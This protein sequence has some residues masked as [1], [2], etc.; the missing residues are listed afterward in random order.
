MELIGR[1]EPAEKLRQRLRS[2]NAELVAVLGRRRVGK[3]FL[4][5]QVLKKEIV[6]HYTG[7]HNGT[8]KENLERFSAT[9]SNAMDLSIR[10][11]TPKNWFEAFDYLRTFIITH[12]TKK[13]K[14]IFLDEFPWIATNKSKFLVA[15]TDFW[16][17]FAADRQDIMVVICGSSA[18]W[19]I[20]KVL[21]N[22]GGL[23]NRVTD[24]IFL[25]PFDLKETKSFLRNK[26]IILTDV[27]IVK[28]YMAI[29]GIP[30]YLEQ[31]QK[32]ESIV[33]GID[34]VCFEKGALL[35][36]EYNELLTSL[37]D[38]AEKHQLV[39]DLLSE[40]PRGLQRAE[41]MERTKLSSGGGTSSIFE[42]LEVSGF[43]VSQTPFGNKIKEK[44]YRLKD[45]YIL[46]YTKFIKNSK[47]STHHLWEK[48]ATLPSYKSW[49]GL[50]FENVCIDHIDP[51][52]KALKIDGILSNS[53]AWHS[54]GNDEMPG[55]QIDLLIDRADGIINIC[56]I[57]FVNAPFTITA[58][59][60]KNLQ[61][62][63]ASFQHFTKTRKT[64]FPTMITTFGLVDNIH[65][66][67]FIQQSV[68][69]KDLFL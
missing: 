65:S 49:S 19:M 50:A 11:N 16:N 35:R 52:K 14:V 57:K 67:G 22:K 38:Q 44:I 37:F 28:L 21:K 10:L 55:A 32:G 1:L 17:S 42:E 46:F 5:K 27:D 36:I 34:R 51:I 26:N 60:L 54:R 61:L 12:T 15:F 48:M 41:I 64:L 30:Y 13:K 29:G 56:E 69:V 68:E 2:K 25:E 40:N 31:F 6:F 24:R 20:Q 8:M 7:L 63:I 53:E 43:I 23:H 59:Y 66:N 4:I 58:E 47:P 62:K 3:T 45:Y 33:Q 18:S 9:L 39:I